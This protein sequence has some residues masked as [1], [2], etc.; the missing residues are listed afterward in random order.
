MLESVKKENENIENDVVKNKEVE[1]NQEEILEIDAIVKNDLEI[2]LP[3]MLDE[4]EVNILKED[5]ILDESTMDLET[6]KR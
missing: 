5:E 4:K 2:I 3:I 1:L 6:R